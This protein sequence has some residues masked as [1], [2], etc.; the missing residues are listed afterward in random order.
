MQK[1]SNAIGIDVSKSALDLHDHLNGVRLQV[2]NTSSG[3]KKLLEWS[4]KHNK[5][6]ASVF[7]CFEHT[8]L[9]SLPLAIFLTE[10]KVP[11]AVVPGMEVK[12]SIGISRGKSDRIDAQR[13][14]E[15]AYL[16][17]EKID[18]YQLPSSSLLELKSLLT[19]REKMV[20]QRAGYLA[21]RKE[22]LDFFQIAKSSSVLIRVQDKMISEL[23]NQIEKVEAEI[24][25]IINNDPHLKKI[26]H[27]VT[28]VKGVG[29]VVGV[30]LIVY[31]N[32]FSTFSDWRKF[33]S[34]CGIAPFEYSSGTSIKGKTKIHYLG[35]KRLKSL[36]SNSATVSIRHNPE[37]KMYYQKRLQERKNKMS[38]INIIRNKILSRVF[39]VVQRGTPYVDTLRFA[40]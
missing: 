37:M 10:N 21:N 35:N 40:G 7:F 6:F 11:Y 18:L 26:F 19:L 29:L 9:Y 24:K 39:A 14:A 1:F 30:S 13:I 17:R 8:G 16:R 20:T 22:T 31:S 32:C 38:T 27:L 2:D 5:D 28:S 34:Y 25:K 4:R 23:D 3:L 36:L 12:R 15:Y 33:A